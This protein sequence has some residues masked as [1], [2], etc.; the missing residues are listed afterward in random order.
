MGINTMENKI[1][2][3]GNRF[4]SVKRKCSRKKGEDE[5]IVR[6]TWEQG[7]AKRSLGN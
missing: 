1:H 3:F 4:M 5:G 6:E 7:K 2:S